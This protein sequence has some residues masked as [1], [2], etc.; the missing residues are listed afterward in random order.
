MLWYAETH[1][2]HPEPSKPNTLT[3]AQ[4]HGRQILTQTCVVGHLP[5]DEGVA[6]MPHSCDIAG[7][8]DERLDEISKNGKVRMP[9]WKYTLSDEDIDDVVSYIKVMPAWTP[10]SRNEG[11]TRDLPGEK[12]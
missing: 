7:G 3:E 1:V 12:Q 5:S 10:R 11:P 4:L 8:N 6:I 9:G 2:A